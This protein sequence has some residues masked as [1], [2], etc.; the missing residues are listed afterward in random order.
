MTKFDA[1]DNLM[2][3]FIH[4]DVFDDYGTVENAIDEFARVQPATA[5]RLRGDIEAVLREFRDDDAL[6]SALKRMG[7]NYAAVRAGWPSYRTWL[8][9]VADR[10]DAVLLTQHPQ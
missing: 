4:E 5:P 6:R 7:L 8:L 10:V 3:A 2:G 9:A 1:L